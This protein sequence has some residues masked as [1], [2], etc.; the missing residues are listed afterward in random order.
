MNFNSSEIRSQCSSTVRYHR[1]LRFSLSFRIM[2]SPNRML[3]VLFFSYNCNKE[4]FRFP[5]IRSSLPICNQVSVPYNS[6]SL[7][8]SLTATIASFSAKSIDFAS[9]RPCT[10][11]TCTVRSIT[12]AP[13]WK[14]EELPLSQF[15]DHCYRIDHR[16]DSSKCIILH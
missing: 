4:R 9:R 7:G 13:M 6:T 12:K 11:M 10:P 2:W 8:C 14:L 5:Y 1:H 15:H 16:A 3:I